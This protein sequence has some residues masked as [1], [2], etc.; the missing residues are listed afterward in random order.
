MWDATPMPVPLE[1]YVDAWHGEQAVRWIERYEREPSRS[2]S[3]SGSPG[4]TTRGTPPAEAVARY[5]DVEI[6]MPASTTR[7]SGRDHRPL[8][9]PAQRVPLAV[10]HRDD[11][12]RRDPGHAAF[13]RRRHLGDRPA[14]RPTGRRP[15]PKG[16]ARR[17]VDHLHERPRRD[18]GEPRA[19]VEVR[20]LR[21]GRARALDHAP[22]RRDAGVVVDALVEQLDVPATVREVPALP[23]HSRRARVARCSGACRTNRT[24][25]RGRSR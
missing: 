23:D 1:A 6:S 4:P 3:S 13:V 25:R 21:A 17:H 5:R 11:D 22:S 10:R 24:R 15:R 8:R 19:D 18:G 12:R 7:P 14:G 9:R 2:F 20:P 16:H